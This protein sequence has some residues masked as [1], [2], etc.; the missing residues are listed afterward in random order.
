MFFTCH[1]WYMWYLHFNFVP[2][3]T[4][5]S[6]GIFLQLMG[7]LCMLR[8]SIWF[9]KFWCSSLW[10]PAKHQGLTFSSIVHSKSLCW[11]I[12]A[13]KASKLRIYTYIACGLDFLSRNFGDFTEIILSLIKK[14]L[15]TQNYFFFPLNIK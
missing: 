8:E 3:K 2:G 10:G 6:Q 1:K 12:R 4:N 13:Q 14:P 5:Q 15:S 9:W 7:K 11:Q